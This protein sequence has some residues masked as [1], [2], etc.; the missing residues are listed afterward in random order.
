MA[1]STN[2]CSSESPSNP[3]ISWPV[4]RPTHRSPWDPSNSR[5]IGHVNGH[6][7]THLP[8]TNPVDAKT[9]LAGISLRS[10]LL[11][12]ILGISLSATVLLLSPP[13]QSS[14]WRLPFFLSVLSLFHFLEFYTT[15]ISNP[16]SATISAFLLSQNGSA[17]NIAHTL[18]FLECLLGHTL[19]APYIPQFSTIHVAF[20]YAGLGLIMLGQ[21]VRTLAMAQA[22][23][24][25]NHIVQSNRKVGHE[26]VKTGVYRW[27][28]HPSYCGFFWWGLGT[29]IVLGNGV[30]FVGY[31]IVLWK[32]FD[33]RIESEFCYLCSM[34]S[35]HI[36]A[37]C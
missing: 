21:I 12:L 33:S 8:E 14:L 16:S 34:I 9:S 3:S 32:F 27:L 30:C 6:F 19:L 1:S 15:S 26:L 13:Y 5:G 36:R 2:T 17:Y 10:Q 37:L 4:D 23:P 24:N 25:F 29:Q 28:R 18:A 11:G 35:L 31:G 7:R 22:G 20:L